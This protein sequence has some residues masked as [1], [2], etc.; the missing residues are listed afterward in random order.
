MN[1]HQYNI[2]MA[3]FGTPIVEKW[4]MDSFY[5]PMHFHSEFQITLIKKG[6]GSLFVGNK[7]VPYKEGDLFLFGKNLPHALKPTMDSAESSVFNT[8]KAT[9]LFFD[10]NKIEDSLRTIPEASRIVK[11]LGYAAH[12]IKIP[13]SKA[14]YLNGHVKELTD[15]SG[16]DKFLLFLRLLNDISKNNNIKALSSKATPKSMSK[17]ANPKVGDICDFIKKNHKEV[18]TLD[19]VSDFANMSPTGF[20]RFFKAK[21]NKTF[22]Q[23]LTEV[24]IGSACELLHNND[25]NIFDCCYGSGFNNLSNFHKHFKKHTGMS[26]L[27]YRLKINDKLMDC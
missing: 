2:P 27:E 19:M 6:R 23:Y 15:K 16:L 1:A 4:V 20:C 9:T 14:K 24:R 13:K 21:T 11:L 17:K 7:V 25:Y 22:S 18:I 12:G 8:C 3:Q 10:Q 26:P 5:E